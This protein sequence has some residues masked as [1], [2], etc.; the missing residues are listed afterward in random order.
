MSSFNKLSEVSFIVRGQ[1]MTK[2]DVNKTL[3]APPKK[4]IASD[5]KSLRA[6]L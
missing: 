1:A 2:D 3:A 5:V 4:R 6:L